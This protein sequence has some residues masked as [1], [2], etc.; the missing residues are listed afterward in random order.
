[1]GTTDFV[2]EP[3][4]EVEPAELNCDALLAACVPRRKLLPKRRARRPA[5]GNDVAR[6]IEVVVQLGVDLPVREGGGGDGA[7]PG[8]A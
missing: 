4:L 6:F 8:G 1:M 2:R 5:A 7:G 3:M